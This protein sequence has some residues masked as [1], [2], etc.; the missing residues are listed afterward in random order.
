MQKATFY[1]SEW[2][3]FIDKLREHGLVHEVD[4]IDHPTVQPWRVL[5]HAIDAITTA[6][7]I[8]LPN[9]ESI[10]DAQSSIKTLWQLVKITKESREPV[11]ASIKVSQLDEVIS[12]AQFTVAKVMELAVDNPIK[13][14]PDEPDFVVIASES[15]TGLMCHSH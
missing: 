2:P 6:C 11:G 10:V 9:P 5:D 14:N 8:K 1:P 4:F 12:P 7:S 3:T 15:L 13:E